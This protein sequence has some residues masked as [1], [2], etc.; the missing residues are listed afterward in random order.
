MN[1]E[2]ISEKLGWLPPSVARI[3]EKRMK[4]IP[5]IKKMLDKENEKTM[6]VLEHS[7]K[8]YSDKFVKYPAL[9]S[10]G[11]SYENILLTLKQWRFW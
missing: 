9:P 8:P 7:L 11:L 1:I 4:K 6:K 3:I 2:E 5:S 10:T